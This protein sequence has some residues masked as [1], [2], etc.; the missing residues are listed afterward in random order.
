LPFCVTEEGALYASNAHIT[1]EITA[2]SGTIGGF[3][4]SNNRLLSGTYSWNADNY[5]VPAD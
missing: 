4:I 5:W 1:G 2:N 3:T